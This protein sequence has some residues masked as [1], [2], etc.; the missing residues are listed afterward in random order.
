MAIRHVAPAELARWFADR[1]GPV[2]PLLLDVREPAE[3]AAASISVPGAELLQWP[4]GT[5]PERLPELEPARPT[6]VLCHSGQ[7]S[8]VVAQFLEHHGFTDVVN[9]EGGIDAWSVQVD[10]AVPRY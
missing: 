8:Q 5:L 9:V 4:M 10:P 2:T 7:R 1:A 3:C 6:A